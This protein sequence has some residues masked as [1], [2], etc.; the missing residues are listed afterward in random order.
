MPQSISQVWL[1]IVFSTKDRYSFLRDPDMRSG[2]HAYLAGA[3]RQL[4]CPARIVNG[5]ADHVHILCNLHRTIS[6]S[7]L[8]RGLKEPSS[9]WIKAKGGLLKKFRWQ[10][11]YAAFSV[12]PSRLEAVHRYIANQ[13][14][15]HRR[16]SFKEEL[17]RFLEEYEVAYDE[18]FLW[19]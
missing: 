19:D 7:G 9:K 2:A 1:H 15:R 6:V 3:C 11:G 18:R 12:S 8:L 4:K 16:L 5:T 17:L 10:A 14:R 13:E